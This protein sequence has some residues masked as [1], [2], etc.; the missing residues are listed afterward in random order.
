MQCLQLLGNLEL[1]IKTTLEAIAATFRWCFGCRE[2][3]LGTLETLS[4]DA[5]QHAGFRHSTWT[6]WHLK[7][8]SV[9]LRGKGF[10]VEMW[11]RLLF[12]ASMCTALKMLS[13]L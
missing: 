7:M 8:L 1:T 3:R 10:L 2:V 6:L 5:G 12:L 9:V 11:M 4:T 13:K